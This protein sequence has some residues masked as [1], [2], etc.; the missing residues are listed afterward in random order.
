[1]LDS[2]C[3][4]LLIICLCHKI[5]NLFQR[6]LSL[7]HIYNCWHTPQPTHNVVSMT[8]F[9]SFTLMAGHPRRIHDLHP[10]QFSF[11]TFNG[12]LCFTYFKRAQGRRLIITDGSSAANSSLITVSQAARS[13][14]Y[15]HLDF[16]LW[17]CISI[18]IDNLAG[19]AVTWNANCTNFINIFNTK[20]YTAWTCRL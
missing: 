2:V 17:K 19:P 16:S 3:Y 7:I 13:V 10:T 18:L 5:C 14:S 8:A 15:T 4:A 12:G 20:M 1:M 11:S 9:L 6:L